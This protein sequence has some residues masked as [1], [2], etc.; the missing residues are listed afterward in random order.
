MRLWHRYGPPFYPYW[1]NKPSTDRQDHWS[2]PDSFKASIPPTRQSS[3]PF[4]SG[5]GT[6]TARGVRGRH[7]RLPP[8]RGR[9]RR[10]CPSGGWRHRNYRQGRSVCRHADLLRLPRSACEAHAA[11]SRRLWVGGIWAGGRINLFVLLSTGVHVSKRSFENISAPPSRVPGLNHGLN[12][13]RRIQV[14]RGGPYPPK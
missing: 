8:T 6:G 14:M 4:T 13:G 12:T 11:V 9:R 7:S 3:R 10:G 5:G 2:L 1:D